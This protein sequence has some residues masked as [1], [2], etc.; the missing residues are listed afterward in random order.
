M[1]AGLDLDRAV[2]PCGPHELLDGLTGGGLNV[3]GY[4]EGGE[5]D[6]QVGL[7]RFAL[8]VVD[9]SGTQVVLGHPEALLHQR[10]ERGGA[11]DAEGSRPRRPA[12]LPAHAE[13]NEQAE[14]CCPEEESPADIRFCVRCR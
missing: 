9:R 3:A 14:N 13:G 10:D 8:V 7:D 1:L 5:H 12:R 4:G 6:G 11:A 2:A